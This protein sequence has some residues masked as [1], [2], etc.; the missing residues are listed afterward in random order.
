MSKN[1]KI[2]HSIQTTVHVYEYTDFVEYHVLIFM[3]YSF[4]L[5]YIKAMT[6]LVCILEAD[7][8]LSCFIGAS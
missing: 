7:N 3:D 5:M 6:V 4:L 8:G 1:D 2:D